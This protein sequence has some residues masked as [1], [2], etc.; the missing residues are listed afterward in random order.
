M[1]LPLF[2][3]YWD[4]SNVRHI[5]VQELSLD[6]KNVELSC[7]P[8]PYRVSCTGTTDLQQNNLQC[9]ACAYI[10]DNT[11]RTAYDIVNY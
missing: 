9:V 3:E 8:V 4:N 1:K 5:A 6:S 10:R 2:S 11:D 7:K